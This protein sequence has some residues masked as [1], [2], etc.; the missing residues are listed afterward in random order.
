[1]ILCLRHNLITLKKLFL[2]HIIAIIALSLVIEE[3]FKYDDGIIR[4]DLKS[5]YSIKVIPTGMKSTKK[6]DISEIDKLKIEHFKILI[7]KE[8]E[9]LNSFVNNPRLNDIMTKIFLSCAIKCQSERSIYDG[10][11]DLPISVEKTIEIANSIFISLKEKIL[12][13]RPIVDIANK[14]NNKFQN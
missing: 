4:K 8:I 3:V 7:N 13:Q 2:L 14:N 1:M 12:D 11:T 10:I 5:D 6:I 9:C